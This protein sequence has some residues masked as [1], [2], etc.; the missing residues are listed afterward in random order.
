MSKN[1]TDQGKV[2]VSGLS[3]FLMAV[4]ALS[5]KAKVAEITSTSVAT[6]IWS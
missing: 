6:S 2:T 3:R 5:Y 1:A 4:L